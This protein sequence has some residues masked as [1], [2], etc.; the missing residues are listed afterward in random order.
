MRAIIKEENID[1]ETHSF[2]RECG[3]TAVVLLKFD[4]AMGPYIAFKSVYEQ[5]VNSIRPL[6]DPE[7]LAQFYVG[8]SGTEMDT[9]EKNEERIVIAR[10]KHVIDATHVTDVL[11][12][13]IDNEI[14]T[15]SAITFAQELITNSNAEPHHLEE[16]LVQLKE[17]APDLEFQLKIHPQR[18]PLELQSL[19][20]AQKSNKLTKFKKFVTKPLD[21]FQ[22]IETNEIELMFTQLRKS[23]FFIRIPFEDLDITRFFETFLT[24]ISIDKNTVFSIEMIQINAR[25]YLVM[26]LVLPPN[27]RNFIERLA[28]SLNMRGFSI[29]LVKEKDLKKHWIAPLGIT[30]GTSIRISRKHKNYIQVLNSPQ[31]LISLYKS[32][33]ILPLTLTTLTQIQESLCTTILCRGLKKNKACVEILFAKVHSSKAEIDQFELPK[34]LS[35]YFFKVKGRRALTDTIKALLL[36]DCSKGIKLSLKELYEF[37][38]GIDLVN[39]EKLVK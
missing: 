13:C 5:N 3:I 2:L 28:G 1:L 38:L 35:R 19:N 6:E 26:T 39:L 12:L 22:K 29:S 11:L 27:Q 10:Q 36:R 20:R 31:R 23:M 25:F 15:S 7:Y 18:I 16:L 14:S 9:L 8:I 37:F 32:K 30:N 34:E 24:Q 17:T 33:T 4:L 21:L